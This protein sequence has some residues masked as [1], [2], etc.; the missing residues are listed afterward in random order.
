[1]ER[2]WYKIAAAAEEAEVYIYEDIGADFFDEGISAKAFVLELNALRVGSIAL[3][4]NSMGGQVFEGQAIYNALVNHP[5]HVTTYIDGLAASIASV[6]ALAG[7]K[8][9]MASNAI[10][11]I[12]DPYMPVVGN[13]AELRKTAD[14]LDV[15][16]ATI[17][18]VYAQKTGMADEDLA[19]AMADE[20]W[21]GA[22]EALAAGFVDEIAQPLAA[23]AH[24]FDLTRFR[25]PPKAHWVTP[26]V[27]SD[28]STPEPAA[29]AE[30]SVPAAQARSDTD[31]VLVGGQLLTF[32]RS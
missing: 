28:E 25:H 22:E 1:M 6:V 3:H 26:A 5:A 2:N 18:G 32:R 29:Q 27:P 20:T 9:V 7:D 4:I 8:V 16:S 11:M 17:R 10:F 30:P 12:H 21:Y 15:L 19:A 13:A 23:A 14:N 24:V 31:Q